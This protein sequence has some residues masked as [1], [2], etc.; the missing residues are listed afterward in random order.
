MTW[1][2]L[3]ETSSLRPG[4]PIT[5]DAGP[6]EDGFGVRVTNLVVAPA[7][8]GTTGLGLA[9]MASRVENLGG[10]LLARA[11]DER[12]MVEARFCAAPATA[13]RCGW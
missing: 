13:S 7:R 8:A 9:G 6:G 1:T 10:S 12:W 5:V 11:D 4:A 3:W 2:A